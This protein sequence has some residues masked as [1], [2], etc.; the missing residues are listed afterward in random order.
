MTDGYL[1]IVLCKLKEQEEEMKR[2]L[3]QEQYDEA[4]KKRQENG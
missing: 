4:M 2:L 3:S 1:A